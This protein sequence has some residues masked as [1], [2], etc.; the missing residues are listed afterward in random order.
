MGSYVTQ[1]YKL[2]PW[3]AIS[4][5]IK[6]PDCEDNQTFAILDLQIPGMLHC[7]CTDPH[8]KPDCHGSHQKLS[9]IWSHANCQNRNLLHRDCLGGTQSHQ[10]GSPEYTTQGHAITTGLGQEA[11]EQVYSERSNIYKSSRQMDSK[12]T[13]ARNLKI[14][15]QTLQIMKMVIG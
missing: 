11:T 1:T 12:T 14:G 10:C 7:R 15:T 3:S 2:P 13:R 9:A 6:I 5:R 8:L 4:I